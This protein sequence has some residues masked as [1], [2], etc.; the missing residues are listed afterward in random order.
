MDYEQRNALRKTIQ[1]FL[2]EN[3]LRLPVGYFSHGEGLP[4]EPGVLTGTNRPK[5]NADVEGLYIGAD[6]VWRCSLRCP[7]NYN[8]WSCYRE[9][10]YETPEQLKAYLQEQKAVKTGGWAVAS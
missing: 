3:D 4:Q 10:S 5:T 8:L 7:F 2:E 6:T 1:T 9:F